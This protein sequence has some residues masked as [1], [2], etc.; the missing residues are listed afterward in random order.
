MN[1]L[2]CLLF[3]LTIFASVIGF[4]YAWNHTYN[5][6]S[7]SSVLLIPTISGVSEGGPHCIQ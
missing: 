3:F 5:S 1:Y 6:V 7:L 2:C 4:F